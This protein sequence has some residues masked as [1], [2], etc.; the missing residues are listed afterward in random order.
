M[1][2][3]LTRHPS[4]ATVIASIALFVSL[5]GVSYGFATGSIDGREIK[6]STIKSAD[7]RNNTV[8]TEDLRN[9]EVRGRDIR[10][11]TIRGQEVALNS[12]GGSDILE[13]A[14]ERVPDADLLDG[15]D[16]TSY[17]QGRQFSLAL[18]AGETRLIAANGTVSVSATCSA[19]G[20]GSDELRLLAAT[21]TQ[22]LMDGP[23]PDDDHLSAIN[24]LTPVTP[25]DQRELAVF[26]RSDTTASEVSEA[27]GGGYVV[28][29]GGKALH[30][31]GAST[32]LGFDYGGGK[33][34]A[35]GFLGST[36]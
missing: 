15:L 12:L 27:N 1:K 35:A 18:A 28:G 25:P 30:L 31:E 10:N 17:Q 14:L 19:E 23:G 8:R 9:N 26:T 24:Y 22:A 6:N 5:G 34:F 11:S 4:P 16:S 33:C 36:G 7:V 3:V 20:S 21:S 13:S 2:K 32:V 29:P